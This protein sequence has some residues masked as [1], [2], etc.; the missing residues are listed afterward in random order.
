MAVKLRTDRSCETLWYSYNNRK[1]SFILQKQRPIVTNW[2]ADL[3]FIL[4]NLAEN[5]SLCN[6]RG[7]K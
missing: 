3:N 5:L 1:I 6:Y 4:I 7:L 2:R